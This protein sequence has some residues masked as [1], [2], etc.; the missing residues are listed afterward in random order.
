MNKQPCIFIVNAAAGHGKDYTMNIIEEIKGQPAEKIFFAE[1]AKYIIAT[2]L[3][4]KLIKNLNS[5]SEK[6]VQLNYLKDNDFQTK[7]LGN[8]NMRETLQLILGDVIRG[9]NSN[10]HVLFVLKKIENN[11]LSNGEELMICTDN[12][13]KNEQEG[14]YPLNLLES[15]E[16]RID[17]IRWKINKDKTKLTDIEILNRFDKLVENQDLSNED[18]DMV[19]KIK[20]KFINELHILNDTKP[21]NTNFEGFVNQLDFSDISSLS[22]KEAFERGLI[23]VFRP[24]IEKNANVEN[25]EDLVTSIKEYTKIEEKELDLMIT[26]YKNYKLEFNF[27]NVNKY[28]YLRANPHHLSEN[29]LEGRKP[30]PLLNS[31]AHLDND[32]K[33]KLKFFFKEQEKKNMIKKYNNG[34]K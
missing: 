9:I 32:I 25:F 27:E 23:F 11:L 26:N 10:I 15:K 33:S 14:L 29:D 24:L 20:R 34:L 30:E 5:D 6:I 21:S 16:E 22:T 13:Y 18:I 19:N 12:R 28:G 3:K 31:P 17:Y 4:K 7:I 8:N 2:S 1:K